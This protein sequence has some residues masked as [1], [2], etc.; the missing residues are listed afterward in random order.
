MAILIYTACQG[1]DGGV[2]TGGL[3]GRTRPAACVD[4]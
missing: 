1:D 3:P 2:E 4:V